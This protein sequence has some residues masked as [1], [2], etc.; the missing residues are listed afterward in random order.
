[1][2]AWAKQR[3]GEAPSEEYEKKVEE[4]TARLY[5]LRKPEPEEEASL[6]FDTRG[7]A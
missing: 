5:M 7:Y 6:R 4:T 1:M 2:Q 3:P